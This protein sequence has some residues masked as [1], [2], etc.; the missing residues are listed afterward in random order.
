MAKSPGPGIRKHG[1]GW[2]CKVSVRRRERYATFPLHT[3]ISEMRAWQK[4]AR[5][6][7]ELQTP[8]TRPGSFAADARRYLEAVCA[9]PTIGQRRRHIAEWVRVFGH[10]RRDTIEAHEIRHERDRLLTTP[11]LVTVTKGGIETTS[12]QPPYSASS[13]N[14]RLRALSNLWTV[15]DGRRA[16]NPVRDVEEVR[17][18][19]NPPRAIPAE[20]I[21]AI[22]AAMPD[23]GYSAR[24]EARSGL[25]KSKA[26]LRVMAATGVAPKTLT[27]ITRA[28]VD[29]EAG[30]LRMPGR[31]KGR[32]APGRVVPLTPDAIEAFR[33]LDA[34]DAWGNFS[35]A[36]TWT[37]FLRACRK[38]GLHGLR[39]YDLRHSF[40]TRL[41]QASG[42][43]HATGLLLGHLSQAT[44]QRYTRAAVDPRLVAAIA[45][46]P[47]VLPRASQETTGVT[48]TFVESGAR[49]A[50]A[51]CSKNEH[52]FA[53]KP[54]TN[55]QDHRSGRSR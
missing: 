42:D 19:N 20:T 13:V 29:F 36:G 26:R 5:A 2:E 40:G 7:L 22:L 24:G 51:F 54:A 44:T 33:A 17:E 3:P 8:R 21:D 35:R 30:M 28:D 18:A 46:L 23:Q 53:S 39:P 25:S 9:M 6:Q 14:Q 10:R 31:R 4:R 11:R 1:A 48:G 37:T 50:E 15:L 16:P 49:G 55:A 34:A 41:Y 12:E 38:L 43:L 27:Q 45:S 32:T 47:R 52:E